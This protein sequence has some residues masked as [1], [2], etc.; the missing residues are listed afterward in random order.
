[1]KQGRAALLIERVVA[2][3][4]A[5]PERIAQ[6]LN[7]PVDRLNS[8]ASGAVQMPLNYQARFSLFVIAYVPA[9][10]RAGNQLRHQ[11]AAAIA[12]ETHRTRTSSE[13]PPGL[14]RFS[15]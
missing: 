3:G 7:I 6:E 10:V 13:P 12:F 15:I 8:F 11:V 4:Q 14:R 1:M 9:L 2:S 5:T